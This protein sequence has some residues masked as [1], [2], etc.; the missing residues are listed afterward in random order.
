MNRTDKS[1]YRIEL[2]G[3]AQNRNGIG[4]SIRLVYSDGEKGPVREVQSGSGYWSQNSFTQVLGIQHGKEV[5]SIEVKWQDGT[6]Q[7]VTVKE[8]LKEY[9]ISYNE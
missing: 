9:Q 6:R 8:G 1:G 2:K 5:R 7:T 3:P 4:S